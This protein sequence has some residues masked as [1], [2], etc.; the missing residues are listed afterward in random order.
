MR[1]KILLLISF[2]LLALS[3]TREAR[4]A[5][6]DEL[7]CKQPGQT[8]GYSAGEAVFEILSSG[9]WTAFLSDE[10]VW[11]RFADAP[12]SRFLSNTGDAPLKVV[13]DIDRGMSRTA[14]ICLSMESRSVKLTLTQQGLLSDSFDIL[15]KNVLVSKDAGT[16]T[17]R[18]MTGL[19]A[20]S[21]RYQ[22]AYEGDTA[23]P[24]VGGIRLTNSYLCFDCSENATGARRHAVLKVLRDET[25]LGEVQVSQDADEVYTDV[26]VPALKALLTSAGT[27]TFDSHYRLSAVVLNDNEE[28]NG[29]PNHNISSILQDLNGAYS[30]LYLSD[31]TGTSGVRVDFGD[32]VADRLSRF[33]RVDVDLFGA[34]LTLSENALKNEPRMFV[35]SGIEPSAIVRSTAGA[36]LSARKKYLGEL[37]DDDLFTLVEI[38]ECVIPVGKGPFI[39]L[40][41]QCTTMNKF[42][43]VLID[44]KGGSSHLMVNTNCS[45]GRD[46]NHI[47]YGEGRVTGVVVHETCDG[48]EW[49]KEVAAASQKLSDYIVDIGNIGRYQIRPVR[50]SEVAL[51]DVALGERGQAATDR[52]GILCEYLAFNSTVDKALSM[53]PTWGNGSFSIGGRSPFTF[54]AARDWTALTED[55][56]GEL[57][58]TAKSAWSA[59]WNNDRKDYYWC[60]DVSTEDLT[61]ANAPLTFQFGIGNGLGGT[62]GGPRYW[63]AEYSVDG[64]AVW[65]AIGSFT[66]PDFTPIAGVRQNWQCPG[67]K[68]VSL[69]LP[70]DDTSI[71]GNTGLKLRLIPDQDQLTM[72][73]KTRY[74]GAA[75]GSNQV[76]TSLNYLAIRYI[77]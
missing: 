1:N 46:G 53:L 54:S 27:M 58:T 17:V 64:G 51:A 7:G 26:D 35:L 69:A 66:V 11:I 76:A 38:Q 36:A 20:S 25:V 41:T 71:F 67:R 62:I 5:P 72:G 10:D 37:T 33:D 13:Y 65:K 24:W 61:S 60:V 55:Q 52:F 47:P 50:R 56:Y 30:T 74:D 59:A 45:W 16:A 77:K 28:G 9:T 19:S 34:T 40:R 70:V 12:S 31:E 75:L 44:A 3:C 23:F 8:V 18:V 29:A 73:D 15:Q 22:V 49:D 4:R 2:A 42:P 32:R 6:I 57:S 43:M 14:V 21:L 63:K 48:F 39:P 68:Y